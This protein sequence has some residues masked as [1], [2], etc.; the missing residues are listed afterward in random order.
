MWLKLDVVVVVVL[1]WK[2]KNGE[3]FLFLSFCTVSQNFGQDWSKQKMTAI[4]SVP[5]VKVWC[6]P[7]T[8]KQLT[9]NN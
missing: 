9:P 6:L 7:T 1:F 5:Q 8:V 3:L 2:L 4:F